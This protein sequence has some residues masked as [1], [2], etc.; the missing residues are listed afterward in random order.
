[1]AIGAAPDTQKRADP[2]P[3]AGF[4]FEKISLVASAY[5]SPRSPPGSPRLVTRLRRMSELEVLPIGR[6]R[7][8]R[9]P[10]GDVGGDLQ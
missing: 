6:V 10:V 9:A 5:W 3:T 7:L 2:R 8:A 1:L 4:S